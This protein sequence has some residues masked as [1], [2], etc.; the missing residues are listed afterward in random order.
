MNEKQRN[1]LREAGRKGGRVKG[2]CKIRGDSNYYNEI[3]KKGLEKR[4][5][6]KNAKKRNMGKS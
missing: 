5:E 1:V 4:R 6:H 2:K 3:R